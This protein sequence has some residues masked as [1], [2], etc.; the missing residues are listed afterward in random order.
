MQDSTIEGL[1][2]RPADRLRTWGSRAA[3]LLLFLV[4]MAGSTSQLG[5]RTATATATGG[6]YTL[7][8]EY[9]R[10]ARAGLDVTWRVT[11]HH[12]GGFGKTLTL[13][14]TGDQFD[15]YETQGFFPSPDSETRDDD[16]VL[17]TFVAP[18]SETFVL[19]YDAYIQP[20]S[21][22]GKSS[23]LAV[24]DDGKPAVT[25]PFSTWLAP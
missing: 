15:I 10:V 17:L 2:P 14:I 19:S 20:S 13:A 11:V 24:L 6:G 9:P 22:T 1:D 3:L 16:H 5:V 12:E 8:F 21:Q 25:V 23:T 18:P 7:T 4:V